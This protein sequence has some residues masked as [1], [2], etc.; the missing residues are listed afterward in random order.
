MAG[1]PVA[2]M[3]G[4]TM[5]GVAIGALVVMM[6][7]TSLMFRKSKPPAPKSPAASMETLKA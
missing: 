2:A 7:L 5:L 6:V 4:G 1:G 3:S